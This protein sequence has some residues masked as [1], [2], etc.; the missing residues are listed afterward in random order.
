MVIAQSAHSRMGSHALLLSKQDERTQSR[1][2]PVM[3]IRKLMIVFFKLMKNHSQC[4]HIVIPTH[5][6]QSSLFQ[7]QMRQVPLNK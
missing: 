4:K 2:L 5:D 6:K 1:N 7:H 3:D